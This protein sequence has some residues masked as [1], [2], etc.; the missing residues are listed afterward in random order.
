MKFLPH[1]S[2]ML[3]TVAASSAHFMGPFTMSRPSTNRN[4]TKAPT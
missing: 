1:D 4:T 2:M 3:S